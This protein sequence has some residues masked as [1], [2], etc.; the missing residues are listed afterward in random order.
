[1]YI[2]GERS[3]ITKKF[4]N[5]LSREI[6]IR[7]LTTSPTFPDKANYFYRFSKTFIIMANVRIIFIGR[8][9]S[10]EKNTS[11]LECE[12]EGGEIVITIRDDGE[13]QPVSFISLDKSTA[14][15]LAKKLRTEINKMGE[16]VHN[17]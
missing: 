6:V 1:M 9:L 7:Y 15:R 13:K 11:F 17:G 14:I 4:K 3:K 10:F 12:L 16:E 8:G 5:K 2:L